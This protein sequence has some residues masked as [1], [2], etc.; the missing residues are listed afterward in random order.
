MIF[1]NNTEGEA[2]TAALR[3]IQ[4]ASSSSPY[5]AFFQQTASELYDSAD[6]IKAGVTNY[7]STVTYGTD[8]F[9]QGM[10]EIAQLI[11]ANLGTRIFYITLGSFDTHAQQTNRQPR[12][13]GQLSGGIKSFTDDMA[14]M[15]MAD[16]VTVMTFSEFGRR[17]HENA[18]G[19]TDHGT[20]SEMF[21]AGA[22]V[23]GG[24]YGAY[25]SL[26]DLD[27]GDLKYNTDFRSVY[28]TMLDKWMGVDSE[29]VLGDRF[30]DLQIF[31]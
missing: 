19:G 18:N 27:Q 20:A 25:P 30:D 5:G 11:A 13:L 17:V 9:G 8:S 21:I 26:T 28:A 4:M 24:L 12:L 2:R 6:K 22:G 15:G 23:T 16:K 14:Q 29:R 1:P 3:R 31:G 7:H 10:Q